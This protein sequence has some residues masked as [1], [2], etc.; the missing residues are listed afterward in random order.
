M[1]FGILVLNE[2][3]KN[4][5]LFGADFFEDILRWDIIRKDEMKKPITCRYQSMNVFIPFSLV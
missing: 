1:L 5:L 4:R 3:P 2:N